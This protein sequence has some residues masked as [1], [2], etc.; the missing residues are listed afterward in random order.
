MIIK[1]EL[2]S[3]RARERPVKKVGTRRRA[4]SRTRP[5]GERIDDVEWSL[6]Q[7]ENKVQI[8]RFAAQRFPFSELDRSIIAQFAGSQHVRGP[9]WKRQHEALVD[10]LKQDV[11]TQG[12]EGF[13]FVA[14]EILKGRL[15]E[16]AEAQGTDTSRLMGM[17]RWL[18]AESAFYYAMHWTLIRFHRPTLITCDHPIVLWPATLEPRS[19]ALR[20]ARASATSLRPDIR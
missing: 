4:Y 7:L 6:R 8:V 1:H 20:T 17:Q 18:Y 2:E 19:S 12:L 9:K 10:Q 16:H 13:S 14:N 11:E 15:V 3:G 5:T